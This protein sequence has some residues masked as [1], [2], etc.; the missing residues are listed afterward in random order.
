MVLFYNLCCTFIN[1]ISARGFVLRNYGICS[2]AD[3]GGKYPHVFVSSCFGL[4]GILYDFRAGSGLQAE[5]G[6]F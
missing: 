3:S 4:P 5:A 1:R 2:A 6:K